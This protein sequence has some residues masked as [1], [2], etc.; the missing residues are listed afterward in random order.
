MEK[1]SNYLLLTLLLMFLLP[2]GLR[3][4]VVYQLDLLN[5]NMVVQG[6]STLHD[7]EM[8]V[9][10]FTSSLILVEPN[11]IEKLKLCSV[12]LDVKSL[13][14][15]HSLMDK[16]AYAALKENDFPKIKGTVISVLS[17]STYYDVQIELS[18]AGVTKV[19]TRSVNSKIVQDGVIEVNGTW[20]FK[21]SEFDIEAPVAVFGT[22]KTG[23]DI[24]VKFTL[25]YRRK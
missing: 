19:F 14:S 17:Q 20:E 6:T 5:S 9:I 10:E 13:E 3:S 15:E 18:I 23:D 22:I 16:K 1:G 24:K 8:N 25:L 4:Q 21:M 12:S 11:N 2:L 7:W